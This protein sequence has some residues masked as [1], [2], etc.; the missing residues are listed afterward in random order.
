MPTMSVSPGLMAT[1]PGFRAAARRAAVRERSTATAP[2]EIDQVFQFR[3][4][5][6]SSRFFAMIC[7]TSASV[8]P[9]RS[10]SATA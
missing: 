2:V 9:E 10:P 1:G 6:L 8:M 7:T 3:L 4:H 5:A